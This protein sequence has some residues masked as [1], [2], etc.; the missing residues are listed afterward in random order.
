MHLYLSTYQTI[1]T[2]YLFIYLSTYLI[3]CLHTYQSICLT[4]YLSIQAS[5]HLSIFD[6]IK[7]N[8]HLCTCSRLH[9]QV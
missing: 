7:K 1:P 5:I 4:I 9:G 2:H 3:I 6:F 8:I